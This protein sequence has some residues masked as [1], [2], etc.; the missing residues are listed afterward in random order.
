APDP[1]R[2]A[3]RLLLLLLPVLLALLPGTRPHGEFGTETAGPL[4]SLNCSWEPLGDLGAPS[5]LHLQSQKY[6]SS[7]TQTVAVPAGQSW[8][9]VPRERLTMFDTL[10]VWG[11]RAGQPLWPPVSVNLDTRMKPSA[12]RL[13]PD[14]DFSE[15]E[16]LEATVQWAP[17]T[18]PSHKVLICQ[19][20][21]R[22]CR[23]VTWTP[24]EPEL[25][26]VPLAPLE[27]QD[28]ELA[29]AYELRARCRV[30]REQDLWGE[31]SP[32]LS[33]QTPPSAP[34]DVWV[35]GD[36]CG[37]RGGQEPLLR[38][39][40]PGPCVQASYRVWFGAGAQEAGPE[41]V[42][43]C[44]N[45]SIPSWTEWARVSAVNAAAWDALAN[46]SL[47]CLAP[48]SGPRGVEACGV[49][50]GTE[51]LV[52]WQPGPG[53]PQEHVVDW[54]RD[55]DTLE[56]FNW[57]R[58]PP[59]NLS[60]VLPGEPRDTRVPSPAG[61][62]ALRPPVWGIQKEL[63]K[64][65]PAPGPPTHYTVCTQ[66]PSV[67]R[68]TIVYN[69]ILTRNVTLPDLHWGPCEL[70]VMASTMAGQG[71]PGPSLWLHLPDNTLRW[72]VLLG[73]L[74][75]WGLLLLGCGLGLA[76]P[77]RC[78]HLWHKVLPRWIWE[79]VPD[80]AHSNSGQRHMEEVPQAQPTGDLPILEVEEMELP[81]VSEPP[82]APA[83]LD[84]GYE[85]HFLPTPEEL[86]L[87]G[88]PR[89]QVLA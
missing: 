48:G 20:Y 32:V 54:A 60:A 62:G 50:G 81:P 19:F 47:V 45:L 84:S 21:Y 12:P 39:K 83:L 56:E 46:L 13:G 34:R 27:V 41:G 64:Q 23:E 73:F 31:W 6:H 9:A 75:L 14:V 17:P 68:V 15:D 7:R 30:E 89:P 52:T 70:W 85:K 44:C 79:K 77:G 55:G 16:P 57:I 74:C 35:S 87:L 78:R 2:P 18:W 53:E 71:P 5:A 49:S 33:F 22:R 67:C 40:G 82:Q 38:W 86:G 10:L 37:A 29:A 88:P 3:L 25:K 51:M 4:G 28:L 36:L 59:G 1:P 42:V 26:T 72:K 61:L 76:T 43:P 80:P 69:N 66:T 24:L 11:T 63:G 65:W 8:V 58:L